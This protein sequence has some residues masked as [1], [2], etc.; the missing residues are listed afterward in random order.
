MRGIHRDRWIPRT[1]G[2]LRGKCFHLMTSS[3]WRNDRNCKYMFMFRLKNLVRKALTFPGSYNAAHPCK[4]YIHNSNLTNAA[5][6]QQKL[7][8]IPACISNHILSK[9]GMKLLNHSETEMATPLNLGFNKWF[10]P[11]LYNR[12]NYL[13]VVGVKLIPVDIHHPCNTVRC[14]YMTVIILRQTIYNSA[15]VISQWSILHR[16]LTHV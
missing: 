14:Q 7:T 5:W 2:Q 13:S 10:H 11:T 4:Q 9:C 1:K 6:C 8:L 3:W 15:R 12:C 16:K